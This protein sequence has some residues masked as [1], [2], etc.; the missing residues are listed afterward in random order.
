MLGLTRR[1]GETVWIGEDIV[2]RVL[3]VIGNQVRLGIQAP[4]DVMIVREEIAD[5]A[6]PEKAVEDGEAK[7]RSPPP[8][9]ADKEDP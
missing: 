2:M 9:R 8:D 3:G 5:V 6:R 7:R 1:V 4:R